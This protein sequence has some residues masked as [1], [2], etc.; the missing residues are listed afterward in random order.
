MKF[1]LLGMYVILFLL[2][3]F[4]NKISILFFVYF[5]DTASVENV[6]NTLSVFKNEIFNKSTTDKMVK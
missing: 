3:L 6:K 2:I 1:L 4:E 5:K